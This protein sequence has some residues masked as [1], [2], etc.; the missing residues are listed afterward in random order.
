MEAFLYF[1]G[2]KNKGR[3][4]KKEIKNVERS[5]S[6]I[7]RGKKIFGAVIYKQSGAN[8]RVKSQVCVKE[9]R[10]GIQIENQVFL[11]QNSLQRIYAHS[12]IHMPLSKSFSMLQN[13]SHQY[14]SLSFVENFN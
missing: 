11:K 1:E 9:R 6:F 3:L 5:L 13:G 14:S 7:L 10:T 12:K 8:L 4:A 2:K